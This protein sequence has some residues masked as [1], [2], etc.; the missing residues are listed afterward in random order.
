MIIVKTTESL[1]PGVVNVAQATA[2]GSVSV[3]QREQL[4]FLRPYTSGEYLRFTQTAD[5][6]YSVLEGKTL[7]AFL[8]AHSSDKIETTEEVY[9]YI[10]SAQ[11]GPFI[12][13]RQ[14]AVVPDSARKGYGRALYNHLVQQTAAGPV[15]YRTAIGFIWKRPNQ[16]HAS[17][18]FN[19]KM[20]AREIGTYTLK[21]GR[22][23]VGIWEI[24]LVG[25]PYLASTPEDSRELSG[26]IARRMG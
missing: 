1:V 2:E 13:A 23:L 11:R 24:P 6:F 10:K 19:R 8:L 18:S 14:V 17:E 22:G 3:D 12:V 15:K 7:V 16:N 20:G 26:A 5:H 21:G 4:G 9:T 25:S